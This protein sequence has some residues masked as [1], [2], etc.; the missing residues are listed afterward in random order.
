LQAALDRR[1]HVLDVV[2]DIADDIRDFGLARFLCQPRH[3]NRAGRLPHST[4]STSTSPRSKLLSVALTICI[5]PRGIT[6]A[7]L[8]WHRHHHLGLMAALSVLIQHGV[9]ATML[10]HVPGDIGHSGAQDLSADAL[11]GWHNVAGQR[12]GG[13][14]ND[15]LI[16]ERVVVRVVELQRAGFGTE[17]S[18][19][20][21][22]RLARHHISVEVME[23]R[24]ADTV[25]RLNLSLPL[26]HVS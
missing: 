4:C 20:D 19:C 3:F 1:Q 10:A 21:I 16:H 2:R 17:Y 6:A 9:D 12:F 15:M 25:H 22:Q 13:G 8:K 7:P 18:E 14:A 11:R 5:T 24:F 26:L 23:H